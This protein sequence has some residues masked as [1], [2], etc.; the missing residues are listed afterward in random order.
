M[1]EGSQVAISTPSSVREQLLERRVRL[2]QAIS[3]APA[4]AQFSQLLRE[5]DSALERVANGSYGLCET[6][7]DPIE[8]ERLAANPLLRLCL[9]HLTPREQRA[10]EDDLQL[11]SRIQNNLLPAK[12]LRVGGWSACYHYE[13]F[14]PVSGDYCDLIPAA[15][16]VLYFVLGDVAGKGIAASML[17]SQLHAMFRTLITLGLAPDDLLERANR[18]F[19]ETALSTHYATVICGRAQPDGAVH[20]ANAGHCPPLLLCGDQVS[21]LESTGL[22]LGMF[23]NSQYGSVH[24]KLVAGDGLLLYTDGISESCDGSGQEYGAERLTRAAAHH[25]QFGPQ[26]LVRGCLEDLG[27]FARGAAR[28]DDLSVLAVAR[29]A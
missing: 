17:M 6:C 27:T 7:H 3:T 21:A 26:Q 12:E 20:L 18:I 13:A 28:N 8:A 29:A 25:A 16:E 9:G 1:A 22:P 15:G 19:C 24:L 2:E 11:A 10:L 5:V 14:G 23:G 4:E